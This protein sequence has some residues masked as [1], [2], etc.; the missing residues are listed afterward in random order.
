MQVR[1]TI[2]RLLHVA[3]LLALCASAPGCQDDA[4]DKTRV[5]VRVDSDMRAELAS[6]DV[7]VL[8]QKAQ[9]EGSSFSFD[10]DKFTLPLSFA[11]TPPA[12]K[13]AGSFLVVVRGKG[14]SG[15]LLVE[16]KGLF[17]FASGRSLDASLWL[18]KSCRGVLCSALE[19]CD[20][21]EA[22]APVCGPVT[23]LEIHDTDSEEA[24]HDPV[25]GPS[26]TA[27]TPTTDEPSASDAP[28]A[29]DSSAESTRPDAS[30]TGGSDASQGSSED[31]GLGE[32]AL[33]AGV[34]AMDGAIASD[35]AS[36][37]RDASSTDTGPPS[38][39]WDQVNWDQTL[40]Q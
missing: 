30:A 3:L 16:A 9:N 1:V 6:I 22:S 19:T 34:N 38:A 33:D 20:A 35:A 21:T 15:A 32:S 27:P 2:A 28:R 8:D 36:G 4:A 31:A 7:Q 14:R 24:S 13:V 5:I 26:L 39:I 25:N 17:N 18:L 10:L 23:A 29:R 11:V 40:W 12:K 37:T